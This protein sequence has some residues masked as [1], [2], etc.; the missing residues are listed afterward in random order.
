[1]SL[2]ECGNESLGSIKCGGGRGDLLA[3]RVGLNSM[4]VVRLVESLAEIT[5]C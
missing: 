1:M 3:F 2:C 4:E 5:L